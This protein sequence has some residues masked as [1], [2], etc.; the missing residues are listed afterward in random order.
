[1]NYYVYL[2]L[3]NRCVEGNFDVDYTYNFLTQRGIQNYSI[4]TILITAIQYFKQ[5]DKK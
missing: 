4:E 2:A 5:H 1:M 3:M